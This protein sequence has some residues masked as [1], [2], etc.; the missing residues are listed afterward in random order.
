MSDYPHLHRVGAYVFFAVCAFANSVLAGVLL[1]HTWLNDDVQ[2]VVRS[3]VAMATFL[4][5]RDMTKRTRP[6]PVEVAL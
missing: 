1:H 2:S 4:A 6:A 3:L 5:L